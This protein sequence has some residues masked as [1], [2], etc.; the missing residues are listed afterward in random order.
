MEINSATVDL[1]TLLP[2]IMKGFYESGR[3]ITDAM[4]GWR[5]VMS[6]IKN[7]QYL[8]PA[9]RCE[10]M[11]DFIFQYGNLDQ[12]QFI[13][14]CIP[15]EYW[16]PARVSI[17]INRDWKM[18]S[19]IPWEKI[20][21]QCVEKIDWNDPF[22]QKTI[23]D[24]LLR[25]LDDQFSDEDHPFYLPIALITPELISYVESH[26]PNKMHLLTQKLSG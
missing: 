20:N 15:L 4:L 18:I 23:Q 24:F 22:G 16:T 14:S 1:K 10:E 2:G 12:V 9:L 26:Y 11:M 13:T 6:D 17:L 3:E 5:L 25:L 8:N 21:R 19:V 7:F